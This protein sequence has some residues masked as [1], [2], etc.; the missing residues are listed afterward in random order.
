MVHWK[1]CINGGVF[2]WA[3]RIFRRVKWTVVKEK[4]SGELTTEELWT[5]YMSYTYQD[6][7]Q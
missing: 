7:P 6:F 4:I 3:K 1:Q 5:T 2:A